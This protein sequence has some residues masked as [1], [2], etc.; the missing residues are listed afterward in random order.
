MCTIHS[1]FKANSWNVRWKCILVLKYSNVCTWILHCSWCWTV[2]VY[3]SD[4]EA[5]EA[6]EDKESE[7]SR[8]GDPYAEAK[9]TGQVKPSAKPSR[10]ID[11]G[12]AAN[13]GKSQTSNPAPAVHQPATNPIS[14][15]PVAAPAASTDLVDLFAGAPAQP[16]FG[17]PA[18][19][20]GDLFS[21]FQSAPSANNVDSRAQITV[22][23]G[24]Q[25]VI[26][27]NRARFLEAQLA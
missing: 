26:I 1:F 27:K 13:F 18:S 9:S 11:L 21:D 5:E 22:A 6:S 14:S 25:F 7:D 20:T 12:A 19:P 10:T 17:A 15:A 2:P 24:E 23:T 4:E 3:Y 16:S 8:N